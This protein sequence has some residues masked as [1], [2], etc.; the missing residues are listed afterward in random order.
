MLYFDIICELTTYYLLVFHISN[1]NQS[2]DLEIS[3]CQILMSRMIHF[4]WYEFIYTGNY[5]LP[6]DS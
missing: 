3:I 5:C 6:Y 1:R 4:G 2:Q